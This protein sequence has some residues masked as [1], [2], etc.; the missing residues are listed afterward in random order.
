LVAQPRKIPQIYRSKRKNDRRD[1]EKLARTGRLD[2]NS[3]GPIQH[4]SA[5]GLRKTC[6]T[7]VTSSKIR[8]FPHKP[9]GS[10]LQI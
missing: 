8:G 7:L 2:P 1:A 9:R 3:M 4:R 5:A 10:A 6:G